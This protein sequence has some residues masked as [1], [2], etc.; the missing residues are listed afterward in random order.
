MEFRKFFD[1][2]IM[3]NYINFEINNDEN[4][5]VSILKDVISGNQLCG[6]LRHEIVYE[7]L[8]IRP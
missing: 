7:K 1:L 6:L 4:F 3:F 8:R 5:R 2:K